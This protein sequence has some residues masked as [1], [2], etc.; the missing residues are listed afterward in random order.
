MKYIISSGTSVVTTTMN[1]KDSNH[2]SI[3]V[4]DCSAAPKLYSTFGDA[5]KECIKVNNLIGKPTFK[6]MPIE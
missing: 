4:S 6:V 5:M 3:V 2:F 1:D